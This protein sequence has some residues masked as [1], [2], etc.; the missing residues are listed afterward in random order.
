M[1]EYIRFGVLPVIKT[2]HIGDFARYGMVSVSYEDFRVGRIPD[3]KS[4]KQMIRHNLDVL[5]AFVCDYQSG[6]T[7]LLKLIDGSVARK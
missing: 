6:R 4:Y 1:I 3:E 7:E 2:E 5:D